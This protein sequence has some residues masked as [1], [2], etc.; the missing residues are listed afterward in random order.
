MPKIYKRH[1]NICRKY[2]EKPNKYYCSNQC[3]GKGRIIPTRFKKGNVPWNKGKKGIYSKDYIKKLRKSHLGHKSS[4]K[5]REIAR[6]NWLKEK[7]PRW[8]GGPPYEPYGVD[9]TE[10]LRRSIR[11]RDNYICQLCGKLQGDRVFAIHHIDYDKKNDNPDNLI[12]LCHS[13]HSKTNYNRKKW[14]NYFE[15]FMELSKYCL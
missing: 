4:E 12:T 8:T 15:R 13:C 11:E 1:C 14:Q 7:N 5:Q 2:Y 10:T 9:W 6:K 3:A